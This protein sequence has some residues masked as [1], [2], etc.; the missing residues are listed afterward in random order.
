MLRTLLP[1][2]IGL[3]LC[4]CVSINS[5]PKSAAEVDFDPDREGRTGWSKYEET[6]VFK[7]VDRRTAY[8][9]AKSGL[10]DAGFTIKRADFARGMVAGEHGMTANDW[11]IV[12]GV[13][14][15]ERE[16]GTAVKVLVQGSK[17]VGF[18]GD[19]TAQSWPQKILKG[20]REYV[21]TESQITSTDR[22][23]FR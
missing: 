17:D 8:L 22:G 10:A 1:T 20:M 15:Q 3:A 19:M 4:G 9:A 13:Y 12:A 14:V 6:V 2:I 21:L 16:E 5:L 7:S 11:N 23:V 18:Q